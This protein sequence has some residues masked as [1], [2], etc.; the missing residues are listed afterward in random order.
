MLYLQ[1][2]VRAREE[3]DREMSGSSK[4]EAD[5]RTIIWGDDGTWHWELARSRREMI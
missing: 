3:H 1:R 2:Q 5:A 4:G